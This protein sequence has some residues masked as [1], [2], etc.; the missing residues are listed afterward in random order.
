MYLA[1]FKGIYFIEGTPKE[2]RYIEP[3]SGELNGAFSQSQLKS[4][5]DLK[6]KM[7]EVVLRRGGN[8]VIDFEYGQRSRFWKGLFG[9]DS[10]YWYGSGGIAKIDPAEIEKYRTK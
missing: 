8:C 10:V 4:L 5:D 7:R 2:A 9:L 6:E 1:E 3:I